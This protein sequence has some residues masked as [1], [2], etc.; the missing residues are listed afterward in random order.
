[1]MSDLPESLFQFEV[2]Q[3]VV[4]DGLGRGTIVSRRDGGPCED[5]YE[6]AMHGEPPSY[7]ANNV[8]MF[9]SSFLHLES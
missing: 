3:I 4:V 2:G 7:A 5:V 9:S 6:V 8:G 1:M